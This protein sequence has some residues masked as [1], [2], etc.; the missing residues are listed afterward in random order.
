MNINTINHAGILYVKN[1]RLKKIGGAI[2]TTPATSGRPSLTI[3]VIGTLV[4][5]ALA[6]T[7]L[8]TNG[9]QLHIEKDGKLRFGLT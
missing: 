1:K 4:G 5:P 2:E 9:P 6:G 7:P 8:A 3:S